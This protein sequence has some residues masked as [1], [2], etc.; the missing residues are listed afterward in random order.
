MQPEDISAGVR[1]VAHLARY[2]DELKTRAGNLAASGSAQRRGYFTPE[3]DDEARTMLVWAESRPAN[4]RTSGTTNRN[5]GS[6]KAS[7]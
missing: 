1:T 7:V 3:E 4:Q 2:F 5:C 6:K